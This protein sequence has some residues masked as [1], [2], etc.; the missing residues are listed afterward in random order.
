MDFDEQLSLF[1][2]QR[3]EDIES[4]NEDRTE[5]SFKYFFSSGFVHGF[6][7]S[8]CDKKNRLAYISFEDLFS[9]LHGSLYLELQ[10]H[11]L[12]YVLVDE[13]FRFNVDS[14][15]KL[16]REVNM[17]YVS[18]VICDGIKKLIE[19]DILNFDRFTDKLIVYIGV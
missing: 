6:I 1:F 8:I 15:H 17:Y 18:P 10:N 4:W 14:A 13:N 19:K 9:Y 5:F 2:N 16:V 11:R 7:N 12:N 3:N